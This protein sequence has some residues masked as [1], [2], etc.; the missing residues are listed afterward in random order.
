M[1]IKTLFTNYAFYFSV[2]IK[3]AGKISVRR[4]LSRLSKKKLK[5]ETPEGVEYPKNIK[6]R[7]PFFGVQV[8]N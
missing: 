5:F 4:K 8:D 7:H 2:N 1:Y 6:T 3:P